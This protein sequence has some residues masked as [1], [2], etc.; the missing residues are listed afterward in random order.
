MSDILIRKIGR[1]GRITLNRPKA[2]NALTAEMVKA[3]AEILPAWA[4]DDSVDLIVMDAAGDRA[5][6]SG[7][8]IADIYAALVEGDPHVARDF[9]RLEYPVN[10]ALAHFPKPVVTFL[11]GFTMGGGVGVGCHASHRIVCEE[12]Q[13]AMPECGIGLIPD[14]GGSLLLARAPG[15]LGEYLGATGTRMGSGDAIHAGFADHYVPHDY[16]TALIE[17]LEST[18]DPAAITAA[19]KAPPESLLAVQ[20]TDID[21][22][23]EAQTIGGILKSLEIT[24]SE[25]AARTLKTLHRNAPLSMAATLELVRRARADNRIDAALMNEFRFA[26]RIAAQS[27]FR[28]GIRAAIIDRDKSPRWQHPAPDAALPAEVK[29]ML[30]PLGPEELMLEETP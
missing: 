2:L 3:I 1:A 16:W 7:G 22:H 18:G 20:A 13:I 12:S 23:F 26:Y 29:A 28:E 21:R 25:W 10:A 15:R 11:K 30:E 5:F 9:W 4:D 19:S 24:D 27:D 14:V 8:D 17:T 6:C